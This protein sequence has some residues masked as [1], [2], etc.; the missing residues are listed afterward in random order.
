MHQIVY[1]S[2]AQPNFQLGELGAILYDA[3]FHNN[4]NTVSGVLLFDG[5]RF[6]QALE[7][8]PQ[9]VRDTFA[10]ISRDKRHRRIKILCDRTIE[11]REFGIWDMATEV[12]EAPDYSKSVVEL[13][14][15]VSS[16]EIKAAFENFAGVRLD[17]G[18]NA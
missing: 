5:R 4:R 9:E 6:L 15:S 1:T 11:C 7:G 3:R 10:R 13:V 2:E 14:A 17:K 8:E 12:R 18:V 16:P